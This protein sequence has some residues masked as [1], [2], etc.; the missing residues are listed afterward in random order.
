[1]ATVDMHYV[2]AAIRCAERREV[3]VTPL[4]ADVA[5]T[6]EMLSR[7]QARVHEDQMTRIVQSVLSELSD[8]F[9]GCTEHACKPG[10]FAFM[11]RH[12]LHYESLRA[13]LNQGIQFYKLVTDD[14]HM[15]LSEKGNIA[16]LELK[17]SRPE[18]DPD[19]FYQEF[20]GVIWHRFSSW[21][22]GEKIP[23]ISACFPFDKPDHID[24]LK[25]L[26]PCRHKFKQQ[27][28]MISFSTEFLARHP[29]R[30]QRDLSI[31]LKHSPA[32][33]MTIPGDEKSYRARIRSL[34]LYQDSRVLRC[35]SLESVAEYFN[36]SSQ[37]LRRR[38]K[39]EGTSYHR[40]KEEI[41][42]DMAVEKLLSQKLTVS[43]TAYLLGFNEPRSFSRAFKHWTGKTPTEYIQLKAL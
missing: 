22:I 19:H 35:P 33:M 24:E 40:I 20:W 28:L 10:T 43:E 11:A 3:K 18:L 31:F 6:R 7:A 26:F 39:R 13:V 16:T 4:L 14:I 34:V 32:D 27:A 1:M 17:F 25:Y 41:R 5:L 42:H 23:L 38:L 2:R 15:Q 21:L 37:T 9:M 29:V 30:T 12:S 36:I 8:E